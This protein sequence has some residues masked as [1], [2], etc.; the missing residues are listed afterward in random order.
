MFST[1]QMVSQQFQQDPD[2]LVD[3]KLPTALGKGDLT[4]EYNN[5][6]SI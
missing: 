3:E 2:K 4:V 5:L 1:M 6:L